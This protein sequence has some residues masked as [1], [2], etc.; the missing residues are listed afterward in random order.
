MLTNK[1][2]TLVVVGLLIFALAFTGVA[3]FMN[4]GISPT[5]GINTEYTTKLFDK[6]SVITMDIQVEEKDWT[7]MLENATAEEYICCDVEINGTL[8]QDIG[9]RPKG[10]SSLNT[11][12]S[13][14][15]DRYSFKLEFDHY[16][17]N[18][19]CWGL[20][21]F[22]VNNIQADSTYM[23]EYL[24]Y[25]LFQY[26]GVASPLYAFVNIT[27]NGQ[28]WGLYVAI[29]SL[30]DSF[31]QRNYGYDYGNLYK[32]GN[33]GARG[34]TGMIGAEELAEENTSPQEEETA[35]NWME[36][37]R[38]GGFGGMNGS[39]G[40]NLVYTDDEISSYPDIF[41]YAVFD[42]TTDAEKQRVITA[43]KKYR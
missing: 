43:L 34:A 36:G 9:I 5:A 41:D 4:L 24:S 28:D 10:N 42:T 2:I 15:S 13:S 38:P 1:K 30:E 21:K 39:G 35:N 6:N 31:V 26:M 27:V 11:V 12:A 33:E 37:G 16:I 3:F 14:D 32:P 18:Q 40:A 23:K 20:D 29:E 7:D 17:K 22:V 8:F 25:D 19:T